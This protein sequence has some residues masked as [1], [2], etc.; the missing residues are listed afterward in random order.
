METM[1]NHRMPAIE[2]QWKESSTLL[3][4][5]SSEVKFEE[6]APKIHVSKL[7]RHKSLKKITKASQ[8]HTSNW[9][10]LKNTLVS[11]YCQKT[12]KSRPLYEADDS[13]NYIASTLNFCSK[14]TYMPKAID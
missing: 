1:R 14:T 10:Y 2:S 5:N 12:A 9:G 11:E 6:V 4:A 13:P 8:L 3:W 7:Q